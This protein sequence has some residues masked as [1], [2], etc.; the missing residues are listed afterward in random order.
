MPDIP[1]LGVDEGILRLRETAMLAWIRC[2]NPNPPQWED[3]ED[4]PIV[5]P[6]DTKMA[7][8][9]SAPLKSFAVALFLVPD[10]RV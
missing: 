4:V 2:V 8:R 10:L 1:C 3:P 9:A 7:R 6:V 5:I